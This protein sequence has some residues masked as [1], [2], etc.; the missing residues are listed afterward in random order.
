MSSRRIEIHG[1]RGARGLLPENTIPA[2]ERAIEVGVDALELDVVMTRDGIPVVHHD[3]VLDPARTRAADGAWLAPPG[4]RIDTLDLAALSEFDVGRAVPGSEVAKCFPGQ[5]PCEGARIPTLREV[6]TL[7]KRPG[8]GRVRFSIEI[9]PAPPEPGQ[10]AAPEAYAR[11]VV[12]ALRAENALDR[13]ELMSFD[14][15]VLAEARKRAPE[16]PRVCLSVERPWFDNVLRARRGASPWTAGLD[17]A[18]FGGSVPRLVKA[19]GCGVWGPYY[20]DL[21][22]ETLAEAHSLGLKVVVWTVNEIDDMLAL[23]ERGVDGI[24]TDYPDRA[25]AV[26]APWRSAG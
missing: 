21:T 10:G 11:A 4:K 14:W 1:H 15:R 24:T 23:A 2:F 12:A 3:P 26:L 5:L 18:A 25:V 7:G 20:R 17:V 13:A 19:A 16:L 9:K 6:L 8:A 22:P